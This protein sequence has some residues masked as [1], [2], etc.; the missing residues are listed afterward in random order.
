MSNARQVLIEDKDKPEVRF[1]AYQGLCKCYRKAGD[2]S[3]SVASCA[4][5]LNIREDPEVYC[6]RAEAYIAGRMF[7]SGK[8]F[9]LHTWCLRG[10]SLNIDVRLATRDRLVFLYHGHNLILTTDVMSGNRIPL[11][12]NQPRRDSPTLS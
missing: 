1:L 12:Q 8:Y 2:I 9:L 4:E 7:D 11:T 3:K 10:S 5:A 6:D